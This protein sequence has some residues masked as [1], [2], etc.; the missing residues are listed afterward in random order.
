MAWLI[1]W[2]VTGSLFVAL[3]L[4]LEMREVQRAADVCWWIAI[5][6]SYAGF[7]CLWRAYRGQVE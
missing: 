5:G 6:C 3:A 4:G 2:I 1:Y 7:F